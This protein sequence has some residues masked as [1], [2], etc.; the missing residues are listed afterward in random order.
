MDDI[1]KAGIVAGLQETCAEA[2]TSVMSMLR[3][4]MSETDIAVGLQAYLESRGIKQSWYDVP[5]MVLI[6]VERF[7]IGT[8]STDYGEKGPSPSSYLSAGQFIHVDFSPMDPETGIWGDW[9]STCVY[10]PTGENGREQIAF[11]TEMRQLQRRGIEH[12]TAQSTGAD[13]AKYFLDQYAEHGVTILDV[14]NNVGH[15]IHSGPKIEANRTWLD[16][17]NTKPL[18][19]G[20]FTV[21]PGG[22][23]DGK[24]NVARFEDC[25][26]VP[27]TGKASIIGNMKDVPLSF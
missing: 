8:T 19:P 26:Y 22:I 18:G 11:L 13:V 14:R 25:I 24:N 20:I 27:V 17:D 9:S 5:F 21:E 2:F 12:F 16:L 15:S 10:E 4:G 7:R 23:S 3:S 1:E 6:G